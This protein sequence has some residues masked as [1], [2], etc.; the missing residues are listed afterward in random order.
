MS[1]NSYS[2]AST[3]AEHENE[4]EDKAITDMNMASVELQGKTT[5]STK[6]GKPTLLRR[7]E[8][9]RLKL[10][11]KTPD[12]PIIIQTPRAPKIDHGLVRIVKRT[13]ALEKSTKCSRKVHF[14]LIPEDKL[15]FADKFKEFEEEIHHGADQDVDTD[16][17]NVVSA[18]QS[19]LEQLSSAIRAF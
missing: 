13:I 9:L 19:T 12:T 14:D 3:I 7:S 6:V 10:E 11:A 16:E 4:H 5:T 17:E 2:V 8:R 1:T 18:K 15:A